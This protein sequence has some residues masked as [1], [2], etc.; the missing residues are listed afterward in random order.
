MLNIVS[1]HLSKALHTFRCKLSVLV[2][3][4]PSPKNPSVSENW[5]MLGVGLVS[6][7]TWMPES[8]E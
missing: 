5:G 4:V 2:P 1:P 7:P 8:P 3:G 6:L